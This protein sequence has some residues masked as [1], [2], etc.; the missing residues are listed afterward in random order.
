M[1][2]A[3]K[4]GERENIKRGTEWVGGI[5]VFVPDAASSS[6]FLLPATTHSL[7][8]FVRPHPLRVLFQRL[9]LF[10]SQLSPNN[11]SA[12]FASQDQPFLLLLDSSSAAQSEKFLLGVLFGRSLKGRIFLGSLFGCSGAL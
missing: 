4:Q 7:F 11:S 10:S 5:V 6:L 12:F 3:I 8:L 1:E 9:L 2:I